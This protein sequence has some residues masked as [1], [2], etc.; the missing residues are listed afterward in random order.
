[1]K[2][3]AFAL[4]LLLLAGAASAEDRFGSSGT[5]SPS[6]S[7]GFSYLASGGSSDYFAS[8]DPGAMVFVVDGLAVGGSLHLS[9]ASGPSSYGYGGGPSVGWNL[10][11]GDRF[12]LFPQASLRAVWATHSFGGGTARLITAQA[13]A[14]VLF[15]VV[16]HFFLGAGPAVFRELDS[17]NRTG[18]LTS[19]GTFVFVSTPLLTTVGLQ[20][21]IGGWF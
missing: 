9:Y 17:T 10:W 15:H 20:S 7:I 14:P 13:F 2:S 11:L 3:L 12:S 21:V 6:G 16:P 8:L 19:G 1:M 4:L 18:I 5:I